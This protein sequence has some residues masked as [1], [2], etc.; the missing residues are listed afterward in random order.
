MPPTPSTESALAELTRASNRLESTIAFLQQ[1]TSPPAS[2]LKHNPS[3]NI[4][5]GL[6][7]ARHLLA[8]IEDDAP[9]LDGRVSYPSA[10]RQWG[11]LFHARFKKCITSCDVISARVGLGGERDDGTVFRDGGEARSDGM[12]AFKGVVEK[13][14]EGL[15]VL[16]R[17]GNL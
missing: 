6:T 7:T 17:A 10:A 12:D 9:A 3:T 1:R 14:G 13:L 5:D 2:R 16:V 15:R 11:A 8:C 4:I